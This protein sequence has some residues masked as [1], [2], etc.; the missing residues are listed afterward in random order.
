SIHVDIKKFSLEEAK[1]TLNLVPPS[2]LPLHDPKV[3][4]TYKKGEGITA[5]LTTQ[6]DAPFAKHG[7]QGNFAVGYSTAAG[8]FA[9]I[10]FPITI[11]GFKEA[12]VRGD[13]N[14]DGIT[15]GCD[16]VPRE[17]EYIKKASV[18]IGY[19]SGGFRFVGKVTLAP[20]AEHE[21]EVGVQFQQGQ[22]FSI[23]GMDMKDKHEDNDQHDL[24]KWK[25][26]VSI[27]LA[28]VGV[29]SI[30]LKLGVGVA[31]GYRMPKVKLKDPKIEGGLE[32]LDS[33]GLP[34]ISFGGTVSMGAYLALSFSVE[35]AG[36]IDLI[37]AT[38][39]A[40]IGAKITAMLNLEL[41]ADVDGRYEQGKG[42]L[43]KIDPFVG[44][45]LDLIASLIATL[46]AEVCWFTII[47]KEYTLASVNFAHIDLGQFR[48]FNPIQV[49]LGGPGGTH[50][51]SGL[52]LRDDAIDNMQNGVKDGA[53]KTSDTEANRE[54][55]TK[56]A[57]VLK[58][59]RAA[60]G[61]FEN[62]PAGWENGMV[63]APV[64][65][66]SMFAISGDAW[67][68]YR[69]HADNAETIDPE[70]ACTTP[71]QKLAKAVAVASKSNPA[72]AGK[73]VLEWRRAQIAHMGVNP[74]TGVNVVQER[75]E[76]QAL[77]MEKYAADLAEVQ[78][79]QKEQDEEHARHVAK[80][81]ADFHKAEQEHHHKVASQKAEHEQ[82]VKHHEDE[83]KKAQKQVEDAE[84]QAAKEGAQEK[85]KESD[86][87]P[88]P[89]PPP[90]PPAPPPLAKPEPI[91]VPP[92][93]PLPPPALILP[94]V[95]MPA[96]PS[97]PGVSV[98][99][100][101]P[102]PPV[103]KKAQPKGGGEADAPSGTSPNPAPG[104]ASGQAKQSG[105]GGGSP[106]PGGGGGGGGKGG[107]GG[108]GAAP[109]GP[110]VAA[111]PAGIIS[112]AKTL[113]A[114]KAELSGGKGGGGKGGPAPAAAAAAAP[115]AAAGGG[116]GGP[117]AGGSKD[118]HA[119]AK[120]DAVTPGAL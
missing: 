7:E 117:A 85:P 19:G 35:I 28:S 68:F 26:S 62:L 107:G 96:L 89:P 102:T 97:D 93:I 83:G 80:Q 120:K 70:D 111:G 94:S 88:P 38:A 32:A 87:A 13:L 47:D 33:G 75:E 1:G 41:G 27:P 50:L 115:A 109:P 40:G 46:Y 84:K 24:A 14:K 108:G 39:S 78:R 64:D 15:I 90:Q 119:G 55:K 52:S 16:M 71:T 91:P 54:A 57:P 2:F 77:I 20:D 53:Q 59:M 100:F 22:G 99:I 10:D 23:L 3:V 42:A 58:S 118:K 36:E 30:A 17:N 72:F 92:P 95:T 37:I 113:D 12:T 106:M 112:Q 51:V 105:G 67:D 116:K 66:N 114:K 82:K 45:S 9:H 8:L 11:P 79:K 34:P 101:T 21:F 81:H 74:D 43:L 4:I 48:P 31:A 6:F 76:V 69:E 63:A 98:S 103:A 104:A 60:A 44:A 25:K 18:E 29:A 86:K 49:Q 73:I 5:V 110:A 56:I 61:Q 65:F